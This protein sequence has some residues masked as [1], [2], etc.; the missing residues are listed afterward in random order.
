[1]LRKNNYGRWEPK[2]GYIGFWAMNNSLAM[3]TLKQANITT[4]VAESNRQFLQ[5]HRRAGRL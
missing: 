2:S 3:P 1:M 4:S 5:T